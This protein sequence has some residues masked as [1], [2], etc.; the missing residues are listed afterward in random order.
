MC[1]LEMFSGCFRGRKYGPSALEIHDETAGSL[2]INGKV[3]RE[4]TPHMNYG[5]E[6]ADDGFIKES[7]C[8]IFT[9][10]L[11]KLVFSIRFSSSFL[12]HSFSAPDSVKTSSLLTRSFFCIL[13]KSSL[14]ISLTSQKLLYPGGKRTHLSC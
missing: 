13:Y 2:K 4:A 3:W 9:R 6:A 10:R 8:K 12:I 5:R 7:P 14:N 11:G 1:V